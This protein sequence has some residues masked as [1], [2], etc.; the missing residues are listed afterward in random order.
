MPK[1]QAPSDR[2]AGMFTGDPAH[3]LIRASAMIDNMRTL[4]RDCEWTL[5]V[6]RNKAGACRQFLDKTSPTGEL[7][8]VGARLSQLTHGGGLAPG[9]A[10]EL[11]RI[12]AM[13]KD[14]LRY[15]EFAAAS[16]SNR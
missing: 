14:I 6:E 3:D 7:G 15:R 4:G 2:A 1:Q 11:R 16:M 5:K 8:A 10:P 9:D 13:L 12:N